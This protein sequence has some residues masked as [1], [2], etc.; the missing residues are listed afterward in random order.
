MFWYS[1]PNKSLSKESYSNLQ[2]NHSSTPDVESSVTATPNRKHYHCSYNCKIFEWIYLLFIGRSFEINDSEFFSDDK[3]TLSPP[4]LW[5]R[6]KFYGKNSMNEFS[7]K[8]YLRFNIK[9][10]NPWANHNLTRVRRL[11]RP[12]D[13]IRQRHLHC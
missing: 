11:A 4:N 13:T 3:R 8:W 9:C 12:Q 2:H 7:L 1:L 5:C 6:M 10:C